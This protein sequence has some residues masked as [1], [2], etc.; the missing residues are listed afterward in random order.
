VNEV[1]CNDID[2]ICDGEVDENCPVIFD[3]EG[4]TPTY[5]DITGNDPRPGV[6]TSLSSTKYRITLDIFSEGNKRFDTTDTFASAF[7]G[8]SLDPFYNTRFRS[9]KFLAK[10]PF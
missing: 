1:C 5:N 3:S 2:N 4:F 8:I 6:R 7:K 9:N 10:R